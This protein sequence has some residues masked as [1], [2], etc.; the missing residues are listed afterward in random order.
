MTRRVPSTST[1]VPGS[2]SRSTIR[3]RS[4]AFSPRPNADGSVAS[5][6][7]R[8]RVSPSELSERTDRTITVQVED[9]DD[10]ERSQPT[11]VLIRRSRISARTRG[12]FDALPGL[13]FQG[14]QDAQSPD[15]RDGLSHL[16]N[17][18]EA[19]E[20][21]TDPRPSSVRTTSNDEHRTA[22]P[23]QPERGTSEDSKHSRLPTPDYTRALANADGGLSYFSRMPS[24]RSRP[25]AGLRADSENSTYSYKS[26]E[27]TAISQCHPSIRLHTPA[28]SEVA[29]GARARIPTAIK[30]K[31]PLLVSKFSTSDKFTQKFPRPRAIRGLS[32]SDVRPPSILEE[33]EDILIERVDRWTLHKWSLVASVCT[34]FVYGT[35]GLVC[36]VLTFFGGTLIT[37]TRPV[38]RT[39]T[40]FTQLGQA[41]T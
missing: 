30:D 20:P 19:D 33:G 34:V 16:L 37:S 26:E 1:A 8:R 29:S 7:L 41:Q 14:R 3:H 4:G 36:A 38:S 40:C 9:T 12:R 25:Q 28:L 11:V 5:S 21:Q 17:G 27:G 10:A 6:G 32:V 18:L 24:L 13:P 22:R 15:L 23:A 39:D 31:R 35:A 2:P